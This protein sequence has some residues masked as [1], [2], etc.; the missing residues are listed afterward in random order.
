MK[1]FLLAV[2]FV[3]VGISASA[4]V[5]LS[6]GQAEFPFLA[7]SSSGLIFSSPYSIPSSM[8]QITWMTTLSS[9]PAAAI[10]MIL[11]VSNDN[12]AWATADTSTNVNGEARNVFTAARFVRIT[13]SAR[14]TGG[15]LTVSVIGKSTAVVAINNSAL[16]GSTTLTSGQFLVPNGTSALPS[17]SFTAEPSLGFYRSGAGEI[18]VGNANVAGVNPFDFTPSQ[19]R[20]GSAIGLGWS[21]ATAAAGGAADTGLYRTA[22]ASLALG[23]GTAADTTGV[24]TLSYLRAGA[25]ISTSTNG[26]F[27]WNSETKSRISST[28]DG[29][30]NMSTA[31]ATI[32]SVF[33]VDALPTIASGFGTSPSVTAGS[34]PFAGS[35]NVGTGGVAVTGTINFNGTAYPSAPFCVA[36]NLSTNSGVRVNATTTQLN[37]TTTTAWV[38]SDVVSWICASAK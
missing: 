16:P 13:Q 14:T 12:S 9:P 33:K 7:N 27:S 2:A 17:Y 28:S 34:T 8:N 22:A 25:N 19:A 31:A 1:K 26:S 4:Q 38:A 5:Q 35:V 15:N 21:S 23:N 37:F 29:I 3:L 32:G 10:T 6:P 36:S 20:L 30:M 24:L 18:S 11:E